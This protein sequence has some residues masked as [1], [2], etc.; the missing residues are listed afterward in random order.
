LDRLVQLILR[1]LD[2]VGDVDHLRM[3]LQIAFGKGR[4]AA[5]QVVHVGADAGDFA[6]IGD[7]G[8]FQEVA[9]IFFVGL[10]LV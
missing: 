5:L 2:G 4:L 1:H 7:I 3:A 8:D 6:M 10:D 9:V